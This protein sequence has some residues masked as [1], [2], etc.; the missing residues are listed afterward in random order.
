M[1]FLA[2]SLHLWRVWRANARA[3]FIREMEFRGNFFLGLLRQLL[4]AGAFIVLIDLIF[5]NTDSLSGWSKA[6]VLLIVG[7]SRLAEG[8][9]DTLFTRN[10][11]EFPRSVHDGKFD[12][13]LL[14]PGSVQFYTMFRRLFL[15]SLFGHIAVGLIIITYAVSQF[16]AIPPLHQWALTFFLISLGISIFYSLLLAVASLV[17]VLER[18]ESLWGF[19]ELFTEPLT[20]PFDIFPRAPR[21]MLTYF[22]PL[23]FVVFVPAQ[24]LTGRL[25]W[26][27]IP[28][29]IALAALFLL[30][31]NLAWRAGL[32]RYSS[33][34]S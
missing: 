2:N 21:L 25:Q 26:W 1:P 27:Q 18:L 30:L 8:I 23:A 5:Q 28:A 19:M 7:L 14:R 12:F 34:S 10:I 3:S 29:A 15:Y 6:E 31:A 33:A 22:L 9:M 11:A 4:W 17:F 13:N 32:R 16:T 24:A 20:V